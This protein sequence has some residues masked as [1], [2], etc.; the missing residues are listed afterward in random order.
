MLGCFVP[1][2]LALDT[3]IN[4]NDGF[5]TLKDRT[6]RGLSYRLAIVPDNGGFSSECCLYRYNSPRQNDGEY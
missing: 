6:W 4:G 2:H 1:F 3:P 5:G